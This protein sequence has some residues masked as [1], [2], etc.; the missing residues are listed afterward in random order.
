MELNSG[1]TNPE[2]ASIR[3]QKS[4][5]KNRYDLVA[6]KK[7]TV[8]I[9]VTLRHFCSPNYH[10]INISNSLVCLLQAPNMKQFKLI[11]HVITK[12][13]RTRIALRIILDDLECV[14]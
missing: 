1:G 14:N 6:L 13:C 9:N 8:R 11:T 2:D 5:P 10:E 7:V 4:P 12:A 3:L